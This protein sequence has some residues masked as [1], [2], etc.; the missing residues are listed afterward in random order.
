MTIPIIDT[1]QHLIYSD[2][3]TY[4]WTRGFAA[5]ASKPFHIEDY[6]HEIEET[7]ISSSILMEA[8]PDAWR[9]EASFAYELASNPN[10]LIG[11]VIANCHP[12]EDGFEEYLDSI[13]SDRLVGLRRTCHMEDDSLSQQATFRESVRRIGDCGL[14]F[15]LC[16]LARQLPLAMDLARACPKT[17][18]ILDHCGIPDIAG[19][20]LDPW[21][22]NMRRFAALP[23]V[24]CK[25]SGVLAYC[26]PDNATATAVRPYIEHSIECFGW[27]RVVWGSDWPVC[28]LNASLK[29]WVDVSLEIVG[30]ASESE[31]IRLFRDNAIRL[32]TL[33]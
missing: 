14:T 29:R 21:R 5:L 18:F 19:G 6:L 26:S 15:D 4:G 13:Q 12:E 33:R 31:Q 7:G 8:T 30:A 23:N 24:A 25:I 16:F 32:Y 17:Q 22:E 10:L 3:W 28:N 9:E 20:A 27:D 11:A 2:K 1:H